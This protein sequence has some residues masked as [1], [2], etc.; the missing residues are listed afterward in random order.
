[1]DRMYID[2]R[3]TPDGKNCTLR[4]SGA[5]DELVIAAAQHAASVHGQADNRD[6]RTKI[7]ARLKP[8][9]KRASTL[10]HARAK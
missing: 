9:G 6:L 1:M 3:D 10:D 7:R 2:C 4:M 5:A 8:L